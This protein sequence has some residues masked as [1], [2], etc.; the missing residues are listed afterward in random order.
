LALRVG[1]R[2]SVSFF[3]ITTL[4]LAVAHVA[5]LL[6][7]A[8]AF[9]D[10]IA[11]GGLF[12]AYQWATELLFGS[13]VYDTFAGF[14]AYMS[15]ALIVAAI[16]TI[17]WSL[18]DRRRPDYRRM[19]AGLRIYLR[20]L[21]AAVALGYGAVKVIP[22]Q[23][24]P[25]SLIALVTPLGEFTRMRLLWLFMG[26]SRLYSV[27][28]GIVEVGGGLLLLSR[29]TTALGALV[30]AAAFTN[31]ALLNFGYEV[32]VQLN[33]T[34]YALMAL[35]LLAPDAPRIAN[36]FFF[37]AAVAPS[38]FSAPPVDTRRRW[39]TRVVKTTV[40]AA[41]LVVNGRNAYLERTDRLPLP[42]LYGIYD[43]DEF[44][45][46]GAPVPAGDRVRWHRLIIAERGRAAIQWTA[47]GPVQSY[48]LNDDV[49]AGVLTL[50]GSGAG[51]RDVTLRYTREGD[52]LLL[53]A[54]RVGEDPIQ[55]RLRAV[56][57]TRFPL[58][59]HRWGPQ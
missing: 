40:I 25:P 21:L 45:R 8:A 27:S 43:V 22:G 6:P 38:D 51:P 33:S 32:G 15:T 29:R 2:F 23:F 47:G 49:N 55:A 16:A 37:N 54:G 48:Q 44:S 3:A 19:H 4:Y 56:D 34:I 42:A 18:I 52:G 58:R 53:V 7:F 50:T 1:F 5:S 31:V 36:L 9:A 28:T 17:I 24:P 11:D 35:V 20:Y 46:D 39:L 14:V 59:Q 57:H 41:L 13:V 26:T 30:L 12:A 10:Q